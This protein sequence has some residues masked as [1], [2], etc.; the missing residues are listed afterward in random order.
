MKLASIVVT[1]A[2]LLALAA[3]G[4][5]EETGVGEVADPAALEGTA[6]VLSG[7]IEVDG[8]QRAAPSVSFER[9]RIGGSSGCNQFGGIYE[10]SGSQ[11]EVTEL[12]ST[13]IGCRPPASDVEEEFMDTLE[14]TPEWRLDGEELVLESD[15]GE[16][17]FRAASPEGSWRAISF[18]QGDGVSTL[19]PGT[20]VTAELAAD[21]ALAGSA[22]CNSYGG[23]YKTRGSSIS[24]GA[25]YSTEM[26]CTDPKGIMEQEQAFL[27]AL[28]RAAEFELETGNLVL[29]T[30]KG[31]IV[32]TFEPAR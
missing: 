24:I 20:E 1:A 21:G 3:C 14:A 23:S 8:W 31:T 5:D 12:F 26:A 17:R 16:L 18:L 30:A 27:S 6:W 2:A 19:L 22:G 29:L 28:P 7:G 11:L 32:A 4:G 15:G 10:V 25:L 13:L 9:G